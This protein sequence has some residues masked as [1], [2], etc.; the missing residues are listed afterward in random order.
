M[1]IIRILGIL[2]F[3]LISFG[4]IYTYFSFE[5]GMSVMFFGI[6]LMAT[7]VVINEQSNKKH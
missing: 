4:A 1:M 5:I 7:I 6:F 3:L 2:A